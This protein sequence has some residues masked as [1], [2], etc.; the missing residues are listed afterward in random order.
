MRKN[1]KGIFALIVMCVLLL[2]AN[3]T[4]KAAEYHQCEFSYWATRYLGAVHITYHTYVIKTEE[5]K[6]EVLLDRYEDFYRCECG[7]VEVRNQRGIV[8]HTERCGQ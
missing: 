3:I 1:L 7:K 4:A 8:R 6:C 5:H 2:N